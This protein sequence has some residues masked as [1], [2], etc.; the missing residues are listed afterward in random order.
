MNV[1]DERSGGEKLTDKQFI[2]EADFFKGLAHPT[3]MQILELLR[4]GE[5]CVC[6]ISPPL[7]L[8]QPNISRHLAVLKKEG[9][10]S[11]RKEGLKVI[12]WVNDKRIFQIVD[13]AS[14]ILRKLFSE[15][16]AMVRGDH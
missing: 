1:F 5:R 6:E 13:T 9:L 4:N 7:G 10:V 16:S 14:D 8:D 2:I 11:S 3:R 15:K 12:Y